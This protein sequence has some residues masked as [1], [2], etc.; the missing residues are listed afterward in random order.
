MVKRKMS[1]SRLR[2]QIVLY[3]SSVY[4]FFTVPFY[5][6]TVDVFVIK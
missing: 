1:V 6:D 5:T 4:A 2:I 3:T